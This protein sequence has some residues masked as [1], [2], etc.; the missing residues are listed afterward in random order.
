MI[1]FPRYSKF[2]PVACV[3]LLTAGSCSKK[4]QAAASS[5]ANIT[6]F[7]LFTGQQAEISSGTAGTIHLQI[8]DTI[9]SGRDLVANFKISPGATLTVEG[10][11]QQSGVTKNNYERDLNYRVMAA[12]RLTANTYLVQIRNNEYSMPWGLGHFINKA[13]SNNRNYNWYIDQSTSGVFSSVNCGPASV[14]M[15]IRWADPGFTKTAQ[16]ARMSY[17]ASGGWWFT[18]DINSY[19]NDNSVTHAIIALSENKDS[20]GAILSHQLD[21]QQIIILCLDMNHVR[22]V[23]NPAWRID[24]FYPT[25]PDWGHFIVLKGYKIVDGEL[26]FE[27]FDPYSFGLMNT[28]LTLKGMNRYYRYDDLAAACKPWWNYAFVIAKKG[29]NLSLDAADRKLNPLHVPVAH[30]GNKFF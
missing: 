28:D 25:T 1:A 30:S 7:Y 26:F 5:A 10:V 24:K 23:T 29:E 16:D 11:L 15:A 18:N 8:A 2:L 21:H 6:E 3:F 9:V 22:S 14:T 27:A 17:E 13:A 12:D 4:D 20:T 19:L